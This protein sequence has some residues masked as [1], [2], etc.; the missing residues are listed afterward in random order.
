MAWVEREVS[1]HDLSV[2][3]CDVTGQLLPRRYWS[4]EVD[5]RTLKA[6]EPRYEDLYMR[7]VREREGQGAEGD[8]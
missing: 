2:E 5:G 8:S 6:V 7:Y 1:W 3:Y 4:F